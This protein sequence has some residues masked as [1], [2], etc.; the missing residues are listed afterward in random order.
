MSHRGIHSIA[1]GKEI[2]RNDCEKC[3]IQLYGLAIDVSVYLKHLRFMNALS[4]VYESKQIHPQF[5]DHNTTTC[6]HKLNRKITFIMEHTIRF[7][8]VIDIVSTISSIYS[9]Y[10]YISLW[11]SNEN[12]ISPLLACFT[13]TPHFRFPS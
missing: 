2:N 1:I 5:L 8:N 9:M 10:W 7:I 6:A 4:L 12:R 11:D 3:G 13:W